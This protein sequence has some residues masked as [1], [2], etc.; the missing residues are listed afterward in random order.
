MDDYT[1]TLHDAIDAAVAGDFEALCIA[2]WMLACLGNRMPQAI[3]PR[4]AWPAST[5]TPAACRPAP[6][7]FV[8]DRCNKRPTVGSL[9]RLSTGYRQFGV[10]IS[11]ASTASA[12]LHPQSSLHL[13]SSRSVQ[14]NVVMDASNAAYAVPCHDFERTAHIQA[15]TGQ[16]DPVVVSGTTRG[17][18]LRAR[19]DRQ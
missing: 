15:G 3:S 18:Q 6:D 14:P 11:A 5:R 10:G 7:E 13:R 12:R 16:M 9:R 2:C 4:R 8:R 19:V 17:H 1:R